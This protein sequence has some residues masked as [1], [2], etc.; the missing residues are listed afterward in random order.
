MLV[1]TTLVAEQLGSLGPQSANIAKQVCEMVEANH[2]SQKP[3]DDTTSSKLDDEFIKTL[4]PQKLYFLQSDIDRFNKFRFELDDLIKA[5]NLDFAASV[6]ETYLTRLKERMEIAHKLIDGDHDFTVKETME[7]D[8]KEL[9]W[10]K[11]PEELNE[12]WRKRIKYDLLLLKLEKTA[13]VAAKTPQGDLQSPKVAATEGKTANGKPVETDP[14]KRLHKRYKTIYEA[15]SK[16]EPDEVV[17]MYLTA[18]CMTF[19][20]HSSYMSPRSVREFQIM[21]G[22]KLEGIGAA[23][24]AEDGYTVVKTIVPGG[25]AAADGRLKVNDKIIAVGNG[26]SEFVDVV[27]M[28]LTKVVDMIRGKSGTKVRLKVLAADTGDVRIYELTRKQVELKSAEVKGEIIDTDSRVKG[29]KGRIGIIHIPSFYRDF[30]GAENGEDEFKSTARDVKKVL[31]DF[32]TKGGV[33]AVVVDLRYNGGGSLIEA[34]EVSGLFIDEGPVVQVKDQNGKI[35]SLPDDEPGVDCNKPL[36]VITNRLSASAS[37][38]FAGVIKDYGRGLLV[39]DRTT[40][41]KGTV[42]NVT[43]VGKQILLF[44]P[45]DLGALKLTIQQF[46]RV[47]GDST[48]NLGVPSDVVLPSLMDNMDLGEQF[49]DNAMPFDHIDAARYRKLAMVPADMTTIRDQSRKRVAA[50]SDFQKTEKDIEK[51]LARKQRKMV[52]LN[53]EELRK[54]RVEEEQ[55]TRDKAVSSDDMTEAGPVFPDNSYNNEVL[56]ITM[57]Y[58]TQLRAAPTAKK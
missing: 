54:E 19:D 42:Q 23:L 27:E 47:N 44:K 43:N 7:I 53:E 26:N 41:G 37:E 50:N 52:S 13:E 35:K 15:L 58:L 31:R 1:A 33:D 25:A 17:E 32:E 39:G 49:L 36:V 30:Q 8:A 14:K 48:Q 20:P 45:Q 56:A 11:T 34:I 2:I 57:D 3:I 10:S 51:Y 46:Y 5:G 40:H 16:T 24:Q 22:L 12:R 18:L 28:K 21:M 55:K 9:P 29:T 38:I 4:D 6:Y